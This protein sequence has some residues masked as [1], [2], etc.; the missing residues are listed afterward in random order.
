MLAHGLLLTGT[1]PLDR[2][3]AGTPAAALQTRSLPA[4]APAAVLAP[5]TAATPPV[6]PLPPAA[7]PTP[8]V[9]EPAPAAPPALATAAPLEWVYALRQNGQE[10]RARL[11]WQ[12]QNEGYVLRLER[13][14]AGRALPGWRSQGRLGAQ[15]LAPERYARQRR[16]RDVQATNFRREEGLVSF[17]ASAEQV[18]L[19]A[20]VQDRLSWWLQLA[21]LVAAAPERA[22]PGS[23]ITLPVVGLRG[24]ARDWA[25]EVVGSEPLVLP[26]SVLADTLRLRRAALG[27]YDG[28]IELWLDPARSHLPV[29][30]VVGQLDPV[31]GG[32]A[33]GWELQLLDD[34]DKP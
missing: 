25:F 21:A 15:G 27:P 32:D 17:S 24:E 31:D 20:G 9:A 28:S 22:S 16:G 26:H 29:R 6:R 4:P 30:I 5:A 2:P 13:E 8:P 12:P 7:S 14:L 1:G 23:L 34:G 33:R 19:P 11:S 3:L 10:G 18:P